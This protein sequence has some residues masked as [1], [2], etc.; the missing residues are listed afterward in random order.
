MAT[1]EKSA[2]KTTQKKSSFHEMT[3]AEL[4]KNLL[5][6]KKELQESRFTLATSGFPN[7]SKFK[8]LKRGIARVLTIKKAREMQ[9]KSGK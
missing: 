9:E 2:K 5:E 3:D 4:D 8:T 1:K 6:Y 7:V